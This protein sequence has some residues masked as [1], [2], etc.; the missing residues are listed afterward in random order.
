MAATIEIP[1]RSRWNQFDGERSRRTGMMRVIIVDD[2]ELARRGIRSR[3][4]GSSGY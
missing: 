1:F 3:I 4:Q 2:E